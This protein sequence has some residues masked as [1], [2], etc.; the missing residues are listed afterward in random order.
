[1]LQII[2]KVLVF[3]ITGIGLGYCSAQTAIIYGIGVT[4]VKNGPWVAWPAAGS[5]SADPYTRA[6]FAHTGELPLTSFE[7]IIFRAFEDDKGKPLRSACEYSVQ[8]SAID[9][10]WWTLTV[11]SEDGTLIKNPAERYSFNSDNIALGPDNSFKIAISQNAQPGN[12]IPAGEDDIDIFLTLRLFGPGQNVLN[13]LKN[14]NLPKIVS[15]R[16]R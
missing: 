5:P 7:A 10:R 13:Q 4:A 9:V 15:G 1:M 2:L 12:W 8:G 11:Y 16:C 14:V 6:H 3:V